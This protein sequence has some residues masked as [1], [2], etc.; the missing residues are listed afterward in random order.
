MHEK[1]C[2]GGNNSVCNTSKIPYTRPHKK[3]EKEKENPQM[4]I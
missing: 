3:M 1:I 2:V 4:Y